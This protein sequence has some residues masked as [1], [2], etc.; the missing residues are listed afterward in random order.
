MCDTVR[1]TEEGA[2]AKTQGWNRVSEASL[3]DPGAKQKLNLILGLN[4]WERR[5]IQL[6]YIYREKA[7]ML[8][9]FNMGALLVPQS[10]TREVTKMRVE[11]RC[12]K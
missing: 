11:V 3:R 12:E 8:K 10:K 2:I 6:K 4:T 7:E 9:A 1:Q 5:R